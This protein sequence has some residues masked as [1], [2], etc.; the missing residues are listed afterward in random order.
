MRYSSSLCFH[1]L[2]ADAVLGREL[3]HR[4]ELMHLGELAAVMLCVYSTSD[5]I[6]QEHSAN[7]ATC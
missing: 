7:D 5:I 6:F 4:I 1:S 2:I 3:G